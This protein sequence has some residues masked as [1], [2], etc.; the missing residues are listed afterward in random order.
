VFDGM[1][2]QIFLVGCDYIAVSV[3]TI[4]SVYFAY[5]LEGYRPFWIF[6][7]AGT[8]SICKWFMWSCDYVSHEMLALSFNS[9][10]YLIFLAANIGQLSKLWLVHQ[11]YLLDLTLPS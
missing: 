2:W 6:D 8:W 4:W 5:R 9:P 7:V 1:L 10:L 11:S 3:S